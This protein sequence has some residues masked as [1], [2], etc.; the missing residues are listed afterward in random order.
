MQNREKEKMYYKDKLTEAYRTA[1]DNDDTVEYSNR[2]QKHG[3]TEGI[4][5]TNPQGLGPQE[6]PEISSRLN[7]DWKRF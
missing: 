7:L 3:I 6:T 4:P 1:L 2:L 5:V